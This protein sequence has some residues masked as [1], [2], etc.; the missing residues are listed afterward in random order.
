[1]EIFLADFEEMLGDDEGDH[2]FVP[3]CG[4]HD[5]LD[6]DPFLLDGILIL[7]VGKGEAEILLLL[8]I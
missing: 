1:M 8:G 2:S 4:L 7:I 3:D 5:F 6:N